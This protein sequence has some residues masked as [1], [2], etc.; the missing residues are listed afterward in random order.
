MDEKEVAAWRRL[1]IEGALV[2]CVIVPAVLWLLSH[3][4]CLIC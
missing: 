3:I 1:M 2:L 4:V